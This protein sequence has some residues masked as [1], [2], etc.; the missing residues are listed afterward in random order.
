V[1]VEHQ[2]DPDPLMPLRILLYAVLFWESEW[3]A[4]ES[5]HAEA[6]PL[7]LT[8]VI[9]IVFHTGGRRWSTYRELVELIGGPEELR[10]FAPA[11]RPLFWELAERTPGEL[12]TRAGEWL[13]ALAVVRAERAPTDEFIEVFRSVLRRLEGLSERERMRWRDLLW[14]VLSWALR[15]RPG[16]DRE[17]LLAAARSSQMDVKHQEEVAELSDSVVETWEQELIARGEARGTLK[18]RRADLRLML[19]ERFGL[20]PE[21]LV[22]QIEAIDDPDRLHDAL[23]QVLH[24]SSLDE[25]KL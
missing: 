12:L 14:F 23:R 20:L 4:W 5:G 21:E 25:L 10:A 3:R 16:A 11:W 18:T 15:R 19:E 9:P 7:R 1:L 8:P 17:G 13:A 2:S 24:I 6:E 22:E